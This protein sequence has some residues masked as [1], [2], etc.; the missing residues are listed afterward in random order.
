MTRPLTELDRNL[1]AQAVEL[2]FSCPPSDQAYAVG[3]VI[4]SPG[5]TVISTG[6]SREWDDG[7]HAEE[8]AI[9]KARRAGKNLQ[10]TTIYSSMEPCHPRLSG[11]KSCTDHIIESGIRRVVFCLKEPPHFTKCRGAEHLA[12]AGIESCHDESLAGR[13]RAA[14]GRLGNAFS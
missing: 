11:K 1:L 4:A 13:V 2:S 10:G 7:W 8:I 6:Y 5:G 12:G 14:N 9:E 3:A